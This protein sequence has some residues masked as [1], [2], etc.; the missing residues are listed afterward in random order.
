M[1]VKTVSAPAK[2]FVN[3]DASFIGI[4]LEIRVAESFSL[5]GSLNALKKKLNTQT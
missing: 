2:T 5:K 1:P 4:F 3:A